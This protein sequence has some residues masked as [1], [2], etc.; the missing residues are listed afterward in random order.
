MSYR[1]LRALFL[2]GLAL[3]LAGCGS[4][5]YHL[6]GHSHNQLS[7]PQVLH[8]GDSVLALE[9]PTRLPAPGGF[10]L[11]LASE[12]QAIVSVEMTERTGGASSCRLV[13]RRPGVV[14]VHYINRYAY[15][16]GES[17]TVDR[18]ALKAASVGSF[19]VTVMP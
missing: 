10:Q 19:S 9:T 5:A 2:A 4:V 12:D 16:H 7:A 15:A 18:S 17:A 11:A 8:V 1:N 14:V 13:A 3:L 6:A